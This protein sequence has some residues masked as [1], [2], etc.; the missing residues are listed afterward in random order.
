MRVVE[1][2]SPPLLLASWIPPH[3]ANVLKAWSKLEYEDGNLALASHLS[4][5]YVNVVGGD[6][7]EVSKLNNWLGMVGIGL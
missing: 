1:I 4:L 2:K 3:Q 5:H 6:D 7:A